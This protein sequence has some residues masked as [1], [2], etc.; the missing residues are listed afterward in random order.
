MFVFRD[1]VV[2]LCSETPYLF[3]CA[4]ETLYLINILCFGDTMSCLCFRDTVP[5]LCLETLMF[6]GQWE[7]CQVLNHPVFVFQRSSRVEDGGR[8]S[9]VVECSASCQ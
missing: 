1:T 6:G 2:C 4:S 7:N 8:P 3:V 5:C 9:S